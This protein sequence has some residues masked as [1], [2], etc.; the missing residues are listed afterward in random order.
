MKYR[1]E[2]IPVYRAYETNA[3]C[4]LCVLDRRAE[5]GYVQFFLGSSVMAP[6]MRVEVNKHGFCARHFRMLYEA[7]GKL[8]LALMTHTYLTAVAAEQARLER[9]ARGWPKR[10]RRRRIAELSRQL[11]RT[12]AS[13]MICPRM[14]ATAKRYAFTVV[15]NW[16][17]D[18]AFRRMLLSSRGFCM[19]HYALCMDMA[20]EVLGEGSLRRWCEE[21]TELQARNRADMLEGL[22]T[23]ASRFDYRHSG[24]DWEGQR[25]AVPRAIQQVAGALMVDS[26][27]L[28]E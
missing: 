1:L 21:V 24:G 25:H 19:E 7:E 10:G 13:C 11:R 16:E 3:E 28:G 14:E 22:A 6:E 26:E 20:A 9:R 4:P 5:A 18:D 2:T 23:F 27:D 17:R 8:G 12:R 15:H